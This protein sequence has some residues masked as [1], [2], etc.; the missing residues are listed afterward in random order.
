[1]PLL[2]AALTLALHLDG[3]HAAGDRCVSAADQADIHAV[4]AARRGAGTGGPRGAPQFAWPLRPT[5]G[6]AAF[7]VF[8]YFAITNQFDHDPGPGLL[9]YACGER[10]YDGHSG[11]DI[12]L[13]PLSWNMMDAGVI[14]VVAAAPGE[15]VYRHDGEFDRNCDGPDVPAN[16]VGIEHADGSSSWYIHLRNGS[17]TGLDVGDT[18]ATGDYLGTIGSSGKSS[19]PHLHFAAYDPDGELVDPFYDP[20]GCNDLAAASGWADQLPYNNPQVHS[21]LFT[22]QAYESVCG[23]ATETHERT[24]YCPGETFYFYRHVSGVAELERFTSGLRDGAGAEFSSDELEIDDYDKYTWYESVYLPPDAAPGEWTA[25]ISHR[26]VDYTRSFTVGGPDCPA[27]TCD[28]DWDCPG[29]Q[30]CEVGVCAPDPCAD[31]GACG[32]DPEAMST[33]PSSPAQDTGS[34]GCGVDG[35]ARRPALALLLIVAAVRRRKRSG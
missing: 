33:Y 7:N 31:G 13:H 21:I 30:V 17:V 10:T 26:G 1:M 6:L 11:T 8:N 9:D 27:L 16:K 34:L 32:D 14:T 2:S 12:A 24:H 20:D 29:G 4:L 23:E 5:A 3:G 35:D 25:T 15:I 22:E 28:G 18:V 19:G